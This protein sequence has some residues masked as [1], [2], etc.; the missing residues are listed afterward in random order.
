MMYK[1]PVQTHFFNCPK[2][3]TKLPANSG[4]KFNRACVDSPKEADTYHT[5]LRDGDIVLVYTDGLSDNVFPS[6]ILNIC[7][8]VARAGGS[9]DRQVQVMADRIVDYARQCM[10]SKHKVS[11]F[12][13]EAA[14]QGMFFRGGK[15]DDVTVVLALVRE[16]V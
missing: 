5:K 4:R 12:E 2:Q 1:Q 13:K 10:A 8:L 9:E 16:T 11:P 14:R 7:S 15:M 6:E 3:L